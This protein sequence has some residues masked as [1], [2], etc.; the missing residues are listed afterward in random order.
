MKPI[1]VTLQGNINFPL[2]PINAS[3]PFR[4]SQRHQ[5]HLHFLA[6]VITKDKVVL[7]G[8]KIHWSLCI[9]ERELSITLEQLLLI[10]A[11]CKIHPE[12]SIIAYSI[13]L[14][15]LSSFPSQSPPQYNR[16]RL[17][18]GRNSALELQIRCLVN[19]LSLP[20]Q[21]GYIYNVSFLGNSLGV[22]CLGFCALAWGTEVQSWLED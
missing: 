17:I 22:Q 4:C 1:Y 21:A 9:L 10:S 15:V 20:G 18:W 16:G 14:R 5:T 12:D 7:K 8:S 19:S 3:R 6:G 13:P 11:R 2:S